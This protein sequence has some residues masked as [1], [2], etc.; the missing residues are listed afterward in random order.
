MSIV[1]SAGVPIYYEE[2][3]HGAPIM[4]VHGFSHSLE[5]WRRMGWI[6]LLGSQGRR[7]IGI[8]PRGH[9]R[10]G[11]P[12]DPAAYDG[13]QL[14]DDVLA[15]LD[16]VGLARTDIMGYSMGGRI[17]MSLLARFP[18]RLNSVIIGGVGLSPGHDLQRQATVA[19]AL[20]ADD[21]SSI[22]DPAARAMRL[23]VQ[24]HSAGADQDLEALAAAYRRGGW[25]DPVDEDSLSRVQVPVL[26]IIGEQD[27]GL[28][29]AQKLVGIVPGAELVV[30]PGEDHASALLAQG[31]KDAVA[32]FLRAQS[33]S[34]DQ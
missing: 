21:V 4:L 3:G 10:S 9:G 19:S 7:V 34:P 30:V 6:E 8:D 23:G 25:Y 12:H 15:V 31:Y 1:Q 13:D 11:K 2:I 17:A 22:S 33:R 26:V 20:E 28:A 24:S 29:L 5:S 27:Q 32:S 18:N 16:G 14:A